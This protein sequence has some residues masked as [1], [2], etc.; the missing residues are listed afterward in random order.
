MG[1]DSRSG[2]AEYPASGFFMRLQSRAGFSSGDLIGE[3]STSKL[4]W[5]LTGF[6]SLWVQCYLIIPARG[7]VANK[8]DVRFYVL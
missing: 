8:T 3:E 1:Q 5:L 6:S 7:K 2:S 4:M